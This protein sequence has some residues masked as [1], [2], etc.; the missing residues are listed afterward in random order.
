MVV[1][2]AVTFKLVRFN[3]SVSGE[4]TVC[5]DIFCKDF[6][7][8]LLLLL[9]WF[10][11]IRDVSDFCDSEI[12]LLILLSLADNNPRILNLNIS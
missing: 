11:V 10:S 7:N 3:W 6:L 12:E 4:S 8:A 5:I 2:F 1:S 9:E